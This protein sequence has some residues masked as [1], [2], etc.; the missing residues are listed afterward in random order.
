MTI[1]LLSLLGLFPGGLRAGVQATE[2]KDD[3]AA[4]QAALKRLKTGDMYGGMSTLRQIVRRDPRYADAYFYMAMIYTEMDQY[5]IAL[6]YAHKAV[7]LDPEKGAY[8]NQA[9]AV[10]FR[11]EKFREA[12]EEFRKAAQG[13]LEKDQEK[14]WRNIGLM[15]EDLLDKDKAIGAFRKALEFA[16]QDAESHL[17]LGKVYLDRNQLE[18]AIQEFTIAVQQEPK[19]G[20]AHALLGMSYSRGGRPQEAV[21][22]F[23]RAIALDPKDK[24]AHY[25]LA[26]TLIKLGRKQ[27]GQQQLAL[28]EKLQREAEEMEHRRFTLG[29]TF[30]TAMKHV[31]EGRLGEGAAM[32]NQ[33][34]ALDPNFVPALYTLGFT[35]LTQGKYDQAIGTLQKAVEINPL[36]AGAYAYLGVAYSKTGKLPQALEATE[37]AT[38]IYDEDPQFHNQLGEIYLELDQKEKA[39]QALEQALSLDEK[40]FMEHLNLGSLFLQEGKLEPAQ[41]HLQAAV[42]SAPNNPEAHRLLGLAYLEDGQYDESITHY[43]EAVRLAPKQVQL[44][45]ALADALIRGRR[46][47]DAESTLVAATQLDTQSGLA[48]YNLGELYRKEG[49]FQPALGEFQKAIALKVDVALDRVYLKVG[50][51]YGAQ[52]KFD[53]AVAAVKKALEIKPKNLEAHGALGGLYH[54]RNQLDQ[55]LAEYQAILALDPKEAGAYAEIALIGLQMGK[56]QGAKEAAEKA[57]QL[58]PQNRQARYALGNALLRLGKTEE[59]RKELQSFQ[60]MEAESQA[61]QHLRRELVAL[62][63]EALQDMQR[64]EYEKAIGL[65]RKATE[66]DPQSGLPYLNLGLALIQAGKHEQAIENLHRALELSFDFPEIHRY[67]A[68]EY[69]TLGKLPESEKEKATYALMR[70]RQNKAKKLKP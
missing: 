46:L 19:R 32:L 50:N 14:V 62:N 4:V 35:L 37:R 13:K 65:F 18:E 12:L 47:D 3:G 20:E 6:R 42:T 10:L 41:N 5:E 36:H 22:A 45:L 64:G 68:E 1:L 7:E 43:K 25:N 52:I 27:E 61:A 48:H 16:P 63:Q 31:Q 51:I 53:E 11:Q 44:R 8:H 28:F 67:L 60:A 29:G 70:E 39:Q 15:Y 21:E 17:A 40:F 30:Q 2:V 54:R 23:Q 26:Q 66:D 33:V 59:G 9:G 24:M 38:V 55:A 34:L 69:K 57:L 56:Y 49:K 58:D